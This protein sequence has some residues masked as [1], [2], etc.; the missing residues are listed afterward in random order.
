MNKYLVEITWKK[1]EKDNPQT[2]NFEVFTANFWEANKKVV[3]F[4]KE[5]KIKV[6]HCKIKEDE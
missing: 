4:V 1:T 5:C 6:L 2:S 3:D